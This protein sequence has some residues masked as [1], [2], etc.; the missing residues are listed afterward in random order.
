M[1]NKLNTRTKAGWSRTTW[2]EFI[3]LPPELQKMKEELLA[4]PKQATNIKREGK[5]VA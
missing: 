2:A 5:R 3:T 1:N 4:R